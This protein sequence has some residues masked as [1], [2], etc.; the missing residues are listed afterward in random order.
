MCAKRKGEMK[1]IDFHAHILPNIDDGSKS[2]EETFQMIKE[3]K[4][5]GFEGI[6]STSHYF[7]EYYEVNKA[8][9]KT[10]I[11]ALSNSLK[12]QKIDIDLY[13]GSEIYIS[14]HIIQLLESEK[15]CSLNDTS[16]VLFELP[17]NVKPINLYDVV[18]DMLQYKLVP[19]LAHPERY[20]F[21]QKEPEMI[22]DLIQ[23][24]VLMQ[25]NYGSIIGQ[26]GEKAEII[27]TKLLEN[28]MVH[29]L[30]T[31]VHM[32]NTIYPKIP[33]ILQKLEEIIGKDNLEVISTVNPRLAL[34]NRKINIAEPAE[35][36]LS[37]KEKFILKRT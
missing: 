7:E 14:N 9:R 37:L 28:N 12:E 3:A 13:L 11:D 18:Y 24:G 16:Y 6:V 23:K 29:F 27:V 21:V 10:W 8:E 34:A 25:S 2:V 26:Y 5:A 36:K 17:F 35:I 4:E 20:S 15:A 30:G 22:G 19:V 1:M 32:P 31:D 33:E